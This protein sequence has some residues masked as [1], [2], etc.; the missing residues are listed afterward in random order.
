MGRKRKL[1][2]PPITRSPKEV[3]IEES[4][5]KEEPELIIEEYALEQPVQ[6]QALS[7]VNSKGKPWAEKCEE[8][9]SKQQQVE[10]SDAPPEASEEEDLSMEHQQRLMD[11]PAEPSII[12]EVRTEW[13][14]YD[15]WVNFSYF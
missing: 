14:V 12:N 15:C 8:W 9:I 4:T 11:D 1:R 5:I 6:D 7:A 3:K 2:N 10:N 13:C